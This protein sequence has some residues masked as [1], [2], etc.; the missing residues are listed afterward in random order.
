MCGIAG[1]I[2]SQVANRPPLKKMTDA[3]IHR[4]P[5]GE[6]HYYD[7]DYAFGCRRLFIVDLSEAGAQP[8]HYLDHYV[9][10]YNRVKYITTLNLEKN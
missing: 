2:A 4:G 8:M 7:T 6:G 3:I 1:A 5:D 10:A 9:I